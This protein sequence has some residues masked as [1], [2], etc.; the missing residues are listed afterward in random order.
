MN[1]VRGVLFKGVKAAGAGA[2]KGL[3]VD[4]LKINGH[5]VPEAWAL[6]N[7]ERLA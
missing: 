7:A 3:A 2:E 5:V 4:Q 6:C 1:P